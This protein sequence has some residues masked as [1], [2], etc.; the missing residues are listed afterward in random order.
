MLH[1]RLHHSDSLCDVNPKDSTVEATRIS[2]FRLILLGNRFTLHH[3]VSVGVLP[4][5]HTL[6]SGLLAWWPLAFCDLP[7]GLISVPLALL[8]EISGRDSRVAAVLHRVPGPVYLP[9]PSPEP[10]APAPIH[11]SAAGLFQAV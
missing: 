2:V 9:F 10:A 11:L 1:N 6:H 8:F 5:A 4:A 3:F 7:A